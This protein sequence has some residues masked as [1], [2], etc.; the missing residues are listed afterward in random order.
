MEGSHLSIVKR[1]TKTANR[2]EISP[3]REF[4]LALFFGLTG[5]D[6]GFDPPPPDPMPSARSPAGVKSVN[7][8]FATLHAERN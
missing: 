5:S 2:Y 3:I 8:F 1:V 4:A 6:E 7:S